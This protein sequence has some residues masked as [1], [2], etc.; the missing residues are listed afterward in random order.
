M[1]KSINKNLNGAPQPKVVWTQADLSDSNTASSQKTTMTMDSA[2]LRGKLMR[3]RTRPDSPMGEDLGS[4]SVLGDEV[5]LVAKVTT[6][7]R[8]RCCPQTSGRYVRL[9]AARRELGAAQK[10]A[11]LTE[12]E[13]QEGAD[14]RI[15]PKR[16]I[17]EGSVKPFPMPW[18]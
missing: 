14:L 5:V 6:A 3:K 4:S 8:G 10:T 7:R 13:T 15:W 2:I 9:L 18:I 16:K 12:K 11:E 17:L 1:E